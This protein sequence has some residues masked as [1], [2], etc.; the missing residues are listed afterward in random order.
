M[1]ANSFERGMGGALAEALKQ[2]DIF[3]SETPF[4]FSGVLH[5]ELQMSDSAVSGPDLGGASSG[6]V[7]DLTNYAAIPVSTLGFS[8]MSNQQRFAHSKVHSLKLN[9]HAVFKR[10]QVCF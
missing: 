9:E 10:T 4:P 3:D 2:P 6:L 7:S 8:E 5:Q 1:Y